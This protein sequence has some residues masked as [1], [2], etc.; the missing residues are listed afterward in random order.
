MFSARTERVL[1]PGVQD[2]KKYNRVRDLLIANEEIKEAKKVL[3]LQ[4]FS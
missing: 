3:A 1:L 4:T 2:P